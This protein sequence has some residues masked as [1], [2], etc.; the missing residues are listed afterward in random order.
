[1]YKIELLDN[2]LIIKYIL[3]M[4]QGIGRNEMNKDLIIKYVVMTFVL[5]YYSI[6]LGKLRKPRTQK[7][8]IPFPY[9]GDIKG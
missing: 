5:R 3:R 8:V 1:M 6:N 4:A 2:N 7:Q 9:L